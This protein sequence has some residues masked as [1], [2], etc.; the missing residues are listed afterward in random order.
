L[1]IAAPVL[2][3]FLFCFDFFLDD[4]LRNNSMVALTNSA[5][6]LYSCSGGGGGGD[7]TIWFMLSMLPLVP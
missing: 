7:G 3:R 5:L 2:L 1:A 6:I 4:R